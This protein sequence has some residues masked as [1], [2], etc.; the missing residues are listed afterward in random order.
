MTKDSRVVIVTGGSTGIGSAIASAFVEAGDNVVMIGRRLDALQSA[1]QDIGASFQQAD[2]SQREQVVTAVQN[3]VREHGTVDVL[4]NNAGL[5]L[6]VLTTMPIEEAERAW[7]EQ[8]NTNLK[9]AFL[10][11]MAVASHLRR[12]GGRIVNISSIAA[13]TGG[14]RAG[15]TGYAASKAGLH[16]LTYG[17]ARELSGEGIT[18]N[19]IAPGFIADT[20]FTG[21]WSDERVAGIV[22]QTPAGRPGHP[23]DIAAAALYLASPAASFVTGQILNVNGGWLFGR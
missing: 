17:L 8:M 12:P 3:V 21:G 9:G 2:V 11:A 20:E 13:Y 15:S 4:V 10:M 7:D 1:A 14:S 6:G 5:V 19:A 18:V 23:D 16:G 22:G